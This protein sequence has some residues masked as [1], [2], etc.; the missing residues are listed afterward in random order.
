[1]F[2]TIFLKGILF[3]SPLSQ[4]R[5][6]T[7]PHPRPGPGAFMPGEFE[8]RLKSVLKELTQ[9]PGGCILF[10]DDIHTVTG[11]NAQQVCGGGGGGGRANPSVGRPDVQVV[12][13]GGSG[14]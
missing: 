7:P 3:I 8:E 14:G 2:P 1:M 10:I 11:P 9:V 13:V 5:P 4:T 12:C 6:P